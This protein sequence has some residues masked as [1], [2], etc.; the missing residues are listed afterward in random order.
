MGK[1][2]RKVVIFDGHGTGGTQHP[3]VYSGGIKRDTKNAIS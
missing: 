1:A 2:L 3:R